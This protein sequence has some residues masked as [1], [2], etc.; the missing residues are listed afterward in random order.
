MELT[1]PASEPNAARPIET[2]I[3]IPV[4]DADAIR[5][6]ER[7]DS[8]RRRDAI[9]RAVA[10]AATRF[11][12]N[13]ASWEENIEEVLG[14]LGT[15]TD[16]SRVYLFRTFHDEQGILRSDAVHEWVVPGLRTKVGDPVLRDLALDE[17]GLGRWETLAR[18]ETI[19]GPIS[20]LPE[21]EQR[22]LRARGICSIVAVPVCIGSH[23]WGVLGVTDDVH[24]REWDPAEIDALTTAATMLG[25]TLARRQTDEELRESEERFRH[26]AEVAAEGIVVHDNGLVLDANQSFARMFGYEL[27]ELI[28][29]NFFEILATPESRELIL[30]H[31][32]AGTQGRYEA[33]GV[34]KDGSEIVVELA[35]HPMTW[36]GR[37][38]RVGTVQDITERKRA[39][40]AARRLSEERAARAAAEE[41][42]RRSRFLA[43][44][45]RLLGASFDYQTTLARLARLA[46]PE[47]A[48]FCVVDVVD[49]PTINRLGVAHV[50]RNK[51][52]LLQDAVRYARMRGTESSHLRKPFEEGVSVFLPFI[53][54]EALVANALNEDHLRLMMV[55]RP[56]SLVSVPLKV[57]DRVT[58][59]LTL[60]TSESGRR[61]GP[62]DLALAEELARRAALSVENARLFHA[63]E[64]ATR[65][66]D[67]MLGVVAHDL[68]NPLNTIAMGAS[69]L[70]E[71]I[72]PAQASLRKQAEIMS[73]AADRM[74]RLIQ[75]LLDVRR[76]E[77]GRLVLEPRPASPSALVAD[78]VEM[79]RP[80]ASAASLALET[81]VTSES[82]A[83]LADT[84]RVQ[85]VLSNLVGNAIKFTPAGGRVVLRAES[86]ARSEVR[87]AVADTGPGIPPEN[88]PHV[89]GQ[90]WQGRRTDR[91]G[92]GLGLAIAKGIVEAH[93]G[94]I[95]VESQLGSGS[96]FYF[97][98][99]AATA[100][101]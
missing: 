42:E 81:E 17:V 30:R 94:R 9:L 77:S 45:S 70:S 43:E 65:A 53:T 38:V 86:L 28:G 74:N 51:E 8:A 25:A 101:V 46:V 29:R 12:G 72:P 87:F 83:V 48:D 76:I 99:P 31:I 97:T 11:L 68:R 47:L 95:W 100:T 50:D 5:G 1:L 93:G 19:H 18:G 96:N 15:A 98:L 71:L 26:F 85:Q 37:H 64:H 54:D 13:W 62:E 79:L 84:A 33:V 36:R 69:L 20:G 10:A 52:P 40:E 90:Y 56:H 35:A 34:R 78:A 55:L 32:R 2:P 22:F 49:G 44:A 57:G 82:P 61:Y 89:F 88:L 6:A 16:A 66:R 24:E 80:L 91:R 4:S 60:Y 67:E 23:W 14:Q 92:I 73:R 27:D 63:A 21:R 7:R 59:A 75:D 58:G 41:S 3:Q 39:E